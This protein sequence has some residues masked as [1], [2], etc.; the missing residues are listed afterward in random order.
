M[1]LSLPFVGA[2]LAIVFYIV[3][4][5]GLVA[6]QTTAAQLNAF[7]FAAVSALVGLFSPEAAEKLKQIFSTLLTTAP[8]GRD[9]S[10]PAGQASAA[11]P[12]AAT[13]LEP[14][15]GAVGSTVTIS[16]Q[17]LGGM[18]GVIFQGATASP[19]EVSDTSVSVVVPAA[20]PPARCG[21][22][23]DH[24]WSVCPGSSGSSNADSRPIAAG[25]YST[26][27]GK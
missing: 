3:L 13:G 20:R 6:G 8:T 27:T 17:N 9:S 7:G 18:T 1:Y 4:R 22:R 12:P 23:S 24:G 21:L 16:G 19:A 26:V 11:G 5:G 25:A 10:A 14:A 2:A 15:S